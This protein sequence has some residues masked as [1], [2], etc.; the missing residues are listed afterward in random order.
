M[1]TLPEDKIGLSSFKNLK[2][3]HVK[4]S[5]NVPR[6]VCVCV[7]HEFIRLKL[8]ALKSVWNEAPSTTGELIQLVSCFRGDEACMASRCNKC[9]S[10]EVPEE[11]MN[12]EALVRYEEWVTQNNK[13][14]NKETYAP[15]ADIVQKVRSK[16]PEFKWHCFIKDRQSEVFESLREDGAAVLQVDFSENFTCA[17][18]DEIQ[19][20]H[21]Q[22]NQIT[23]FPAV[24]WQGGNSPVS[25][26]VISDSLQH[27]KE[28]V[29]C[30]LKSLLY[31]M[32]PLLPDGSVLNIF[33]DGCAAQFKQRFNFFHILFKAK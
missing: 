17:H 12:S 5:S 10:L 8:L 33:S 11:I 25:Y 6:N 22:P 21:W 9:P 14:D 3:V 28:S 30:Y 16:L 18:Q 2:P 26:S 19:A 7:H 1:A 27:D 4:Y 24:Y 13:M 29:Y 15:A 20:A 23:L 31:K 32:K